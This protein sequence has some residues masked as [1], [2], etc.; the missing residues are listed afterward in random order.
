[1]KRKDDTDNVPRADAGGNTLSEYYDGLESR[2]GYV[3]LYDQL[4]GEGHVV[5]GCPG[6]QL[7]T[8]DCAPLN[9]IMQ[10]RFACLL[11][12]EGIRGWD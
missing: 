4:E 9:D 3:H 7:T 2:I 12:I 5:P 10:P 1:M 11:G 6:A 8:R